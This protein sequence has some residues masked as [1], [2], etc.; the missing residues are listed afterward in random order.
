MGKRQ[1]SSDANANSYSNRVIGVEVV[2]GPVNKTFFLYVTNNTVRGGANC[3]I[4]VMRQAM[5]DLQALLK[6]EMNDDTVE[7]PKRMSLQFDNCGEN[8]N[9]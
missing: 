7:L 9:R 3:I 5:K 8:K 2:C 6:A 4:E 1:S